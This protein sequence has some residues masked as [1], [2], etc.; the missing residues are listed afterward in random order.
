[1]WRSA[2]RF[3][4]AHRRLRLLSLGVLL[5]I[6]VLAGG[7][8]WLRNSPLVAVE[9]V[10]ISGV[11]GIDA[12][13]IDAA[14]ER[15]A[16]QMSTLDPHPGA[17]QAAVAGF[18]QVRS[19]HLSAS[20]PHSL[21]ITVR[22]Q[23]PVAV[24][25]VDGQRTALAADGVVLGSSFVSGALP[26]INGQ[27]FES[28]HVHNQQTLEYL[29]VLGAAPP[30]LESL[31]TRAYTTPKGLT[32]AMHG[33]LLVYFGDSSRPHAKWDSLTGVLANSSSSGASY[34]DV[35]LPERPAAGMTGESTVSESAQAS[36]LDP[37][38][39]TLARTLEG[40]ISGGASKPASEPSS[41]TSSSTVTQSEPQSSPSETPSSSTAA[42]SENET[43]G[44]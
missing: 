17:L 15:A 7:W 37:N 20:F 28:K 34:V 33:G 44:G 19:L 3:I 41:Q 40:A 8:L 14:L 32:L 31:V 30:A 21:S 13:Q 26:V 23:P 5:A 39:V 25:I 16:K 6:P 27:A 9:H 22:E 12:S 4:W 18:P 1:M 24:L 11:R 29:T 43:T 36:G 2:V 35:R 42:G 10:Q 38:S